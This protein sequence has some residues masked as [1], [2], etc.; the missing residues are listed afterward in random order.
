MPTGIADQGPHAIGMRDPG[1]YQEPGPNLQFEPPPAQENPAVPRFL[2]RE[3]EATTPQGVGPAG[4]SEVQSDQ[5]A[6]DLNTFLDVVTENIIAKESAGRSD[7]RNPLST[8]T[9]LGQFTKG[10][11]MRT[12]AKHRPD[13][14]ERYPRNEILA[15]RTDP[16]LSLAMT[17]AHT[18]D[19]VS[20][21]ASEG[22][23]VTPGNAYLAHFLGVDKAVEVLQAAPSRPIAD[24]VSGAAVRA[25]PTVLGGG[26]TVGDVRN[27][28]NN[29]MALSYQKLGNPTGT[30]PTPSPGSAN[31]TPEQAY[32]WAGKTR[33]VAPTNPM[34]LKRRTFPGL[35]QKRTG[36]SGGLER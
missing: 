22:V 20:R 31:L 12:I 5:P 28:A 3:V 7:A 10:T 29:K 32:Q 35:L 21:L 9:G 6:S 17:R 34:S 36:F 27:W 13:L 8:A 11:W 19:N 15:M 16:E 25:N 14:M 1:G 26:R 33:T 2:G 24:H 23:E 4:Q 30:I 18:G